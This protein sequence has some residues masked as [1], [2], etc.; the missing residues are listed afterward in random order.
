MTY[1]CWAI[2]S[3]SGNLLTEDL[4]SASY[5]IMRPGIAKFVQMTNLVET[6][7]AVGY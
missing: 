4:L 6:S 7:Q 1:Q 2:I 3:D 5:Q